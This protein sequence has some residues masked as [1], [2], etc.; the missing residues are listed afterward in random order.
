M[1]KL[2][3]TILLMCV[4]L[5]IYAIDGILIKTIDYSFKE[6]W[7]NTV[8]SSIPVISTCETVC[9]KQYFFIT[10]IAVDYALDNQNVSNVQY[11][12]KIIKPDN[13]IY[14]SQ[15]NL[16]LINGKISN[17]NNLQ[18]SDAIIK[19]CF[20]NNDAFG[21]YKI[22]IVINDKISGKSKSIN[23]DITLAPLP[24][25]NQVQVKDD[26]DFSKWFATY[27]E[28]PR[29]EEALAYYIYYSQ[30]KLSDKESGFWP[31]FS[32]FLEIAKNNNY[33][34]PQILDCYKQQDLKTKIYL[35]Y[36]LTYSNIGTADFFESLVGDE[37]DAYKNI[38]ETPMIDIYGT[39]SDAS[40]LDMLWGT[41]LASGSY[42]PILKLIQ[43]LDYTK[44]QGDL[45]KFKNSKK[46][47][48]DR[49]NAINNAIYTSLVWSL[50]SN[51]EQHK[52]VKAYCDWAINNESLSI[53][54][55]D[56]LNKILKELK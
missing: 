6:K 47:E 38:K 23:S 52:L 16:P 50:T 39:I 28:N 56:E 32:I 22:E 27:Y 4:A 8:G 40:Q 21:K 36:L 55:K 33:L 9:K 11:S 51:C 2:G 25:Y 46:T 42:Q 37:K 1:R 13:S 26:E 7:G 34:M 41:F 10:A 14:F 31:I 43:T 20:E 30:S 24:V 45:D 35:L 5:Q 3:F 49:Q 44:Y 29:P 18:M 17:K 19:V 48:E 15:E 12:I 54:Q 53:V